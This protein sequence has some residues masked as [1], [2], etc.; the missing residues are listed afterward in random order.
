MTHIFRQHLE[1]RS[2]LQTTPA[3]AEVS[4]AVNGQVG[5]VYEVPSQKIPQNYQAFVET[6]REKYLRGCTLINTKIAT[7][8]F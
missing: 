2:L 7:I 6:I 8:E 3:T 4:G 1:R 5:Q